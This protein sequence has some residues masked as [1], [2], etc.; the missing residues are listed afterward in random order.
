MTIKPIAAALL[1]MASSFLVL[2]TV[3]NAALGA[4]LVAF[5]GPFSQAPTCSNALD[6][7]PLTTN[8]RNV[9]CP[10]SSHAGFE[11]R[12]DT[13]ARDNGGT[14]RYKAGTTIYLDCQVPDGCRA[15]G[16]KTR[17]QVCHVTTC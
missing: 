6:V 7:V 17:L 16:P 3:S 2:D 8:I 4:D 14:W 1:G 15:I 11:A 5:V 12:R 9:H 13:E 10:N